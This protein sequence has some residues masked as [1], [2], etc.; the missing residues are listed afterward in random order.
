MNTINIEFKAKTDQL[1]KLEEKMLALNPAFKGED[2]QVDTYYH[3]SKGRLKLRE[4][5]IEH[6]LIYYERADTAEAKKSDII[7]YQHTPDAA[8]KKILEKTH[9][10]KVIVDKRRR[11]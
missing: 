9:G 6:A 8:L 1:E 3:V 5:N 10:I 11:I 4:G 7:L 2:H